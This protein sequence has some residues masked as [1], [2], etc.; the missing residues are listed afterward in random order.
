MTPKTGGQP[1]VQVDAFTSKPFSGNPAAVCVLSEEAAKSRDTAWM[2][3]VAMEMNLSETAFVTPTGAGD[4]R[5]RLQW[6]AP[7]C[8]VALCGH[9][10]LATAHVLWEEGHA[11]P[12]SGLTFETRSG[13]LTANRAQLEGQD[14]IELDFPATEAKPADPPAGLAE[15]L[16]TELLFVGRSKFDYLVTVGSEAEVRNLKPDF[17]DLAQVEARGVIVTAAADETSPYDVVSRFFAPSTGVPE[18]PVTGSAHCA[19]GPYWMRELGRDKLSAYQASARGGSLQ[20]RVD[21]ER[22]RLVGQ[23]VTVLRG[24]LVELAHPPD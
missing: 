16:G 3:R 15:A 21:G 10:T 22:V 7:K 12:E 20:V 6:F 23:A 9:A 13:A 2:Q 4:N 14:W 18:D 8:E 5:F 11:K 24:E 17:T 1:V 19:I